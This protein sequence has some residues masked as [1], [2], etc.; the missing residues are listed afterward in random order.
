MREFLT[1]VLTATLAL[2]GFIVLFFLYLLSPLYLIIGVFVP[3]LVY[4]AW[5]FLRRRAGQRGPLR[6]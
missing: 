5:L 3:Y 6:R 1:A 4:R 2:A